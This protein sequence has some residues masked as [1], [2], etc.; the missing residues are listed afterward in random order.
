MSNLFKHLLVLPFVINNISKNDPPNEIINP[1]VKFSFE[2][3]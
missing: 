1:A 3:P 2:F